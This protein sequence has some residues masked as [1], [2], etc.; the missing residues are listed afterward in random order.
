MLLP[1]NYNNRS[2]PISET[3]GW[4]PGEAQQ[5]LSQN[6]LGQLI[7]RFGLANRKN[8]LLYLENID[9]KKWETLEVQARKYSAIGLE[10]QKQDNNG[11]VEAISELSKALGI[12]K[13]NATLLDNNDPRLQRAHTEL[14]SYLKS[15]ENNLVKA[16]GITSKISEIESFVA[17]KF[18]NENIQVKAINEMLFVLFNRFNSKDLPSFI[19]KSLDFL[20]DQGERLRD[21]GDLGG[22]LN[23]L[24]GVRNAWEEALTP[25]LFEATLQTLTKIFAV[26]SRE[27]V[28]QFEDCRNLRLV[29]TPVK[30]IIDADNVSEYFGINQTANIGYLKLCEIL[31]LT[32]G[33][34]LFEGSADPIVVARARAKAEEFIE[35]KW[36]KVISEEGIARI[37]NLIPWFAKKISVDSLDTVIKCE[38]LV[39][40]HSLSDTLAK[41]ILDI[42]YLN[43]S[44]VA[45]GQVTP[46]ELLEGVGELCSCVISRQK[47]VK[48]LGPA[49][50]LG[51]V[52]EIILLTRAQLNSK[53]LSLL[54]STMEAFEYSYGNS[55][56][57]RSPESYG[58]LVKFIIKFEAANLPLVCENIKSVIDHANSKGASASWYLQKLRLIH[59]HLSERPGPDFVKNI[60]PILDRALPAKVLRVLGSREN[61][62]D[63][64]DNILETSNIRADYKEISELSDCIIELASAGYTEQKIFNFLKSLFSRA[65]IKDGLANVQS[66]LKSGIGT[67]LQWVKK[68][69]LKQVFDYIRGLSSSY[70]EI[71]ILKGQ[72]RFGSSVITPVTKVVAA[73]MASE[74]EYPDNLNSFLS[75]L[76][77]FASQQGGPILK[78]AD[79]YKL[80]INT[81]GEFFKQKPGTELNKAV[82]QQIL[83][84]ARRAS[85]LDL[86]F[87]NTD[88]SPNDFN[89]DTPNGVV[90]GLQFF[91]TRFLQDMKIHSQTGACFKQGVEYPSLEELESLDEAI[92]AELDKFEREVLPA[93]M[94][95][96]LRVTKGLLDL[97]VVHI[98]PESDTKTLP[99]FFNKGFQPV[100]IEGSNFEQLGVVNLFKVP[101]LGKE[102]LLI[103]GVRF[104]KETTQK[105]DTTAFMQGIIEVARDIGDKNNLAVYL[106]YFDESSGGRITVSSLGL[107]EGIR[108]ACLNLDAIEVALPQDFRM[109]KTSDFSPRWL[110]KL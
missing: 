49:D 102:A 95:L 79:K 13:S 108:K 50:F 35:S 74:R 75:V 15:R 30:H 104:D 63:L 87:N 10:L 25:R 8:D 80:E 40:S 97:A 24:E 9:I 84:Y 77:K 3:S 66:F 106:H 59:N 68:E 83:N 22:L 58:N 110:Y 81:V 57:G 54:M 34:L 31:S 96:R 12:I 21:L 90:S 37:K 20:K 52:R 7:E 45:F 46:S 51:I 55:K 105:L 6:A 33:V 101:I 92:T 76:D 17:E 28:L 89:F 53:T 36:P 1:E 82:H 91:Q 56:Q 42:V 73:S 38:Q 27:E 47:A 109:L 78:S 86:A 26:S 29:V 62:V 67:N 48:G 65:G 70:S 103:A 14:E 60:I 88:I 107:W 69:E 32:N 16:L 71:K 39:N 43:G 44:F 61:Y 23:T 5:E 72:L 11:S 64:I 100:R 98:G 94:T 4:V 85:A 99:D 19:D 41:K 18:P 2:E 93:Q